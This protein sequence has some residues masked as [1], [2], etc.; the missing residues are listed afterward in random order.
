MS[1]APRHVR[2]MFTMNQASDCNTRRPYSSLQSL[3][4]FKSQPHVESR[5]KYPTSKWSDL[6]S[7]HR[8]GQNGAK[9]SSHGRQAPTPHWKISHRQIEKSQAFRAIA[10]QHSP[11][12]RSLTRT[13]FA[14]ALH[15]VRLPSSPRTDSVLLFRVAIVEK[16]AEASLQV[17][18]D[19]PTP[20]EDV[21]LAGGSEPN[22]C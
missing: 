15:V 17:C 8:P 22:S 4:R 19:A 9:I 1:C 6:C 14:R 11:T 21:D 2:S 20:P 10:N 3:I 13:S 12:C 16:M 18:D 7:A 5:R